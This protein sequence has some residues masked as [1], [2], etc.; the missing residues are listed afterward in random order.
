MTAAR[1][2]K[3]P[4]S[5]YMPRRL[6]RER[7]HLCQIGDL[8]TFQYAHTVAPTTVQICARPSGDG[9][10]SS[11]SVLGRALLAA[12][13]G[14]TCRFEVRGIVISLRIIRVARRAPG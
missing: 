14:D 7:H 12:R 2:H 10:A 3:H 9:I 8:V 1:R 6:R 5:L 13:P 4:R 11:R